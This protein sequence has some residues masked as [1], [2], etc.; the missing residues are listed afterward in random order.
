MNI[1]NISNR[2]KKC[3][4]RESNPDPCLTR[5]KALKVSANWADN[6]PAYLA[7][8]TRLAITSDL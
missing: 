8:I 1:S 5:A 6:Q 7:Q 3:P 2:E 4:V